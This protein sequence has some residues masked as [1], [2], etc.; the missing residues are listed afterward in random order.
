MF[1]CL[2]FR[3]ISCL[4]VSLTACLSVD[5]SVCLSL[6]LSVC[7]SVLLS[8]RSSV[9]VYIYP[10]IYVKREYFSSIVNNLVPKEK[11]LLGSALKI[12]KQQVETLSW[13]ISFWKILV[14]AEKY[15][16]H[17]RWWWWRGGGCFFKLLVFF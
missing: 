9:R 15:G 16:M 3:L 1:F 10:S 7:S 8:L 12:R 4:S 11:V 6:S 14:L 13:T 2:S 17:P 5:M